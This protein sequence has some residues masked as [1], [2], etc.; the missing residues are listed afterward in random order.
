MS[1]LINQ[2]ITEVVLGDERTPNDGAGGAGAPRDDAF[3]EQVVRAATERVLES[4]RRE[5]D[6]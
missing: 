2:V 6:R 3:V 5:W 1:V 4:L